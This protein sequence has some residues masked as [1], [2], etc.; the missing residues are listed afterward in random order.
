MLSRIVRESCL[1]LTDAIGAR[2]RPAPDVVPERPDL[3][4][5]SLHAGVSVRGK[6]V[7]GPEN[8]CRYVLCQP[9]QLVAP[10][11]HYTRAGRVPDEVPA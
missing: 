3:D 7:V 11:P 5:Y 2:D 8:L 9:H 10:W 6:D 4:S 1:E